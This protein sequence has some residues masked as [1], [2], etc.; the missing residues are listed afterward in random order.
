MKARELIKFAQ[1]ITTNDYS[2]N[3]ISF[4]VNLLLSCML[5]TNQINMMSTEYLSLSLKDSKNSPL[6]K[7][8]TL[9]WACVPSNDE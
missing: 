9:E 7:E 2:E 3:G 4:G 5:E 1:L 8:M 6:S